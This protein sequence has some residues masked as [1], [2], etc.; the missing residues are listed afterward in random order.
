MDP[1]EQ[2]GSR[3]TGR[4]GLLKLLAVGVGVI[5]L[6][7]LGREVGAYVPRF[8]HWVENLGAWGPLVFVAGYAIATV[9]FVPGSLLTLAAGAIFGIAE[10]VAY[11]FVGAAVGA[12][13]AFLLGRYA[14]RSMLESRLAENERFHRVD[15][16]IRD[17]GLKIVT[18]L[19]LS[20]VFPFN[21]LNYGLG[22]TSVRL[23]DYVIAHLGMLPGTLLYVYYG[24]AAGQVAALAAGATPERGTPYWLVFGLG[25]AATMVVV[26]VVA[27]IA[28]NALRDEG[29]V[30][31]G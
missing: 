15:R 30:D 3:W 26:V 20:P 18:L 17:Q 28:R 22:L 6:Y 2:M 4:Q 31:D 13:L 14:A 21:L 25:L 12:T 27:R 11:V 24:R 29:I 10:G 23:R 8:A 16:A 9:A 7:L 19:R 1:G 5:G